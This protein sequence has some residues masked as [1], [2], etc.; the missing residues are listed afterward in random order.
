TARTI[1]ERG[2]KLQSAR[3]GDFTTQVDTAVELKGPVDACLITVKATQ[4]ESALERVP[5]GEV[6]EALLVPFLNGIDHV[7]RIRNS[8]PSSSVVAATIRVET[9][10]TE[11]GAIR[12]TSPF[13]AV[14]I[15][16]SPSV[17][18]RVAKLAAQLRA[19]GLDVKVR[20]QEV[21]MLWDKLA[22]LGPLAL[23]TTHARANLGEVRAHRRD[24]ARALI[25][26]VSAVAKAEGV[27]ADPEAVLRMFEAA[28]AA[29]ESSMQRDQAAGLPLEL[30]AIGGAILE[31]AA[32][33]GV[34]V[35]VT[36]RLVEE[37]RE[38]EARLTH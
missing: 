36:T 14:E 6:G 25:W 33:A 4:L 34:A 26:E 38:R 10:R 22:L 17:A 8:Y 3:F 28:P 20:D 23:L 24:D 19:T 30:D 29:M 27:A 21:P 31:H 1:G 18:D 13:A 35:P 15:G 5:A 32:R 2:L 7:A 16:T 37:L 11:A 9:A 12:H